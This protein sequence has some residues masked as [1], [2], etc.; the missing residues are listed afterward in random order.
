MTLQLQPELTLREL[1]VHHRELALD[2][3]CR[4]RANNCPEH[5]EL[6]VIHLR[7][8]EILEASLR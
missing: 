1:A 8:A 5:A 3:H 4:A 2:H 6:A 7:E